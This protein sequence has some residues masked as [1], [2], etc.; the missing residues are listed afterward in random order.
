MSDFKIR[1]DLKK[2][3]RASM[4]EEYM[5]KILQASIPLHSNSS[6]V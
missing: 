4:D 5:L 2:A 6:Q 3:K 1:Q